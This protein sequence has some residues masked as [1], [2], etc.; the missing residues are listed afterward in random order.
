MKAAPGSGSSSSTTRSLSN[1]NRREDDAMKLKKADLTVQLVDD[2]Q[3]HVKVDFRGPKYIPYQGFRC[4]YNNTM[5]KLL[6][7]MEGISKRIKR[8]LKLDHE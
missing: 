8:R 1:T 5:T 4:A 2:N 6:S 7:Y 3:Y